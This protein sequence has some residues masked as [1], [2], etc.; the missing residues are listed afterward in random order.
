[1][2]TLDVCCMNCCSRESIRNEDRY[3]KALLDRMQNSPYHE[4]SS[5]SKYICMMAPS[6]VA[7]ETLG[8]RGKKDGKSQNIRKSAV[9]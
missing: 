9:K 7:Q 1:M 2:K 3:R 6:A 4:D 8:K 5:H